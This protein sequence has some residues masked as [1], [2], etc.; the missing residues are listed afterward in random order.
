MDANQNHLGVLIKR[1]LKAYK[2]NDKVN[3]TQLSSVWMQLMGKAI[4]Q[5]TTGIRLKD[6]TLFLQIS[7][8]VLRQELSY[9]KSKIIELVNKELGGDFIH[10]VII[11]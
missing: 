4:A 7:S 5:K 8:E 3:E 10:T 11:R 6:K 2:I 1:L 9:S